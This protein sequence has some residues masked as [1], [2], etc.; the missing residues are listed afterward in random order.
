MKLLT[1]F[2]CFCGLQYCAA[3]GTDSTA[4]LAGA[5]FKELEQATMDQHIW[6]EQVYGPMLLVFPETHLTYANEPD[7]AGVLK[8][9]DGIYKGT[10][11]A[12]MIIGNTAVVW[13]GK[14]WSMVMWPPPANRDARLNLLAHESFHRIQKRM[15]LPMRSPTVDFLATMQGR[16]YFLLELQ[17]L[18]AALAK[19]ADKRAEDLS[20]ALLFRAKQAQLFPKTFNDERLLEM[21]EGLAEYTGVMLGRPATTI[22]AHLNRVIDSAENQQSLIRSAAYI[23]G[24]VYGYLLFQKAPGWTLELDSNASFPAL[25]SKYYQ[26][27]P[28]TMVS[29]A[30]LLQAEKLYPYDAIAATEQ[31]K[32][33]KRLQM[34]AYYTELFTQKPVLTLTLIKMNVGFD[35]RN[36]FDLGDYGTVYPTAQV[37]DDW[38]ALEVSGT[39]MLMKNWH[40][41]TLPADSI[42]TTGDTLKG[43]GWQLHLNSGWKLVKQ[44]ERHYVLANK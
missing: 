21:N 33:K 6:K 42:E 36:L 32:E 38:G 25:I 12:G 23:T 11:P 37:K 19:P 3:Q 39:G 10:L 28:V 20:N 17:A 31:Q 34:A 40:I 8:P 2:L 1:T 5:Y 4:R 18:R 43:D 13:G 15:G 16:I 7:S 29:E 26:I 14:T 41:V 24:P 27:K 22:P 35:P 9:V 30:A 44:D